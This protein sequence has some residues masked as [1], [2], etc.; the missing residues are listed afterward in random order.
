MSQDI[1]SDALNQLMNAKNAN[2]A[3]VS[4][5]HHSRLLLSILS[6]AKLNG[7][8]KDYKMKP[9][10]LRIEIGN[11]NGCNAIKPRFAVTVEEI[12][13]YISRY[14]PA[15]NIGII[16]ISTSNGLMTHQ[17]AIEKNIGGNLVAY[18]Y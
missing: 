14:L 7:Y 4:V 12:E 8:V 11:L 13:K 2:K 1:V 16:I 17:T 18:F 9:S 6:V 15:K 3:S 10:G 5:Q